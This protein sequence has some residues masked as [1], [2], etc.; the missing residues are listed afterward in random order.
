[1][2]PPGRLQA[3]RAAEPPAPPP[4][5]LRYNCRGVGS[6]ATRSGGG[7]GA[8]RRAGGRAARARH[9]RAGRAVATAHGAGALG[10]DPQPGRH[11]RAAVS[12]GRCAPRRVL[13]AGHEPRCSGRKRRGCRRL[14]LR[15]GH[16]RHRARVR[17]PGRRGRRRTLGAAGPRRRRQPRRVHVP[18]RQPRP[19]RSQ[20]RV[21]RVR[22]RPRHRPGPCQRVQRRRR[23]G[24]SVV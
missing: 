1:M 19:R 5:A 8:E 15:P 23:G 18:R 14:R 11:E 13:V 2:P 4:R 22:P 20:R 9:R 16:E 6:W 10:R 3:V 7:A 21:R 17:R 12:V 24:R